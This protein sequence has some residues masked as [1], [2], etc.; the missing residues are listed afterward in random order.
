MNIKVFHHRQSMNAVQQ[1]STGEKYRPKSLLTTNSNGTLFF[2][3]ELLIFKNVLILF[4]I[5]ISENS[6]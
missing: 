1:T 2:L 4:S 6:E 3:K 5:S